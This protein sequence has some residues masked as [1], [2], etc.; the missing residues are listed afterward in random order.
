MAKGD[1]LRTRNLLNYN[2]NRGEQLFNNAQAF[3]GAQGQQFQGDYGVA[4]QQDQATRA[5]A[6]SGFTNFANTGGFT[7]TGLAAIRARAISPIRAA[8]SDAT[9]NIE[10][11]RAAGGTSAGANVLRARLARE[12]GQ[13]ASDATTNAE[14]NIAQLVQSGKLA[15]NQ[16]LLS[17]YGTAPGATGLQSRNVLEN[18]SQGL[19]LLGMDF[20]RMQGLLNTQNQLNNAPGTGD[21]ALGRIGSGLK[22]GAQIGSGIAAPATAIRGIF[23]AG[24]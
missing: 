16:G 14:A 18:S 12:G 3:L 9:R 17:L 8:Y 13:A 19:N 20:D 22:I 10:R 21:V 7:P 1:E 5:A 2:Q 4:N 11:A 23:K 6:T 15:G 24:N